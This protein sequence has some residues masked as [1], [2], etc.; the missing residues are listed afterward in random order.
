M[1]HFSLERRRA[2]GSWLLA[3]LASLL[4]LS[5]QAG[6]RYWPPIVDPPTG[7]HTPGRFVWGELVTS[8]VA[9]AADFYG[10]VFGWT[11]ETYGGDDDRDTYTLALADG[12]PIG[13]MV[14]DQR[15][16]KGKTPSARWVGLISVA[17][18][19]AST[20]AVTAA[21]GK[22]VYAPVMLGERGETAVF[23]DPEG[24]LFGVVNSKNGDPP[25]YAGDVNEWYWVDLWTVD[26]EKAATFYRAVVGYETLPIADDGPR[27]GLNLLSGGF[28]RAGI[29][30]K[31]SKKT[32]STWLP[33]IR[34]ADATASAEAARTAGG[35]V[36]LQP[37]AM[38]RVTVAIIADPTG[39]PVGI[40]QVSAP[41]AQP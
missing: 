11:F 32:S 9:A 2:N 16:M 35:K 19:K 27:I 18:V 21:G 23:K 5:A 10:K 33:Y 34:V 3:M 31:Q 39:A 17:D 8:D 37:L 15:A 40:V 38:N 29:M 24:V 22:V 6:D 25:D 41:E 12:L 1:I 14:F 28:A 13:G 7:K 4:A 36:L 30:Q 20:A 26:V